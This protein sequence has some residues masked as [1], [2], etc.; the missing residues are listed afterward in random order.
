[1]D[2]FFDNME[3]LNQDIQFDIYSYLDAAGWSGLHYSVLFGYESLVEKIMRSL[4]E[5]TFTIMST[6]GLSVLYLCVKQQ[7]WSLFK[8][9]LQYAH[10]DN[11]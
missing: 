9:M 1:M 10:T 6:D 7:N 5:K 8:K 3:K 11:L 4:K 2:S